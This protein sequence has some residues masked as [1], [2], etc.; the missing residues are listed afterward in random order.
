[1]QL[2]LEI[3][4]T[5]GQQLNQIGHV[6]NYIVKILS[7]SLMKET[8]N[9]QWQDWLAALDRLATAAGVVELTSSPQS[10]VEDLF[11]LCK[12]AIS[13]SLAQMEQAIAEGAL[14]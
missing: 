10:R 5:L 4:E 6:Q 7:E 8:L 2:A 9:H 12:P 3:P 13:V 14:E 1:M 11:G